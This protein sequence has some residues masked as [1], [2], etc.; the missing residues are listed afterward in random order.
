MAKVIDPFMK[1]EVDRRDRT[2]NLLMALMDHE[3]KAR[4]QTMQVLEDQRKVFAQ[5]I[6][7][8]ITTFKDQQHSLASM[9]SNKHNNN[10]ND[11][12]EKMMTLFEGLKKQLEGQCQQLMLSVQQQQQQQMLFQQQQQQQHLMTQP[13]QPIIAGGEAS[14][15]LLAKEAAIEKELTQLMRQQAALELQEREVKRREIAVTEREQELAA[16]QLAFSA[17]S[18]GQSQAK[19]LSQG[20]LALSQA[21][22][23]QKVIQTR[24]QAAVR[25]L[26]STLRQAM[27]KRCGRSFRI[28]SQQVLQRRVSD[29][30][31]KHVRDLARQADE[32]SSREIVLQ[33]RVSEEQR[34]YQV[35]ESQ[36]LQL[37]RDLNTA[38][39]QVELLVKSQSIRN[40]QD[41]ELSNQLRQEKERLVVMTAKYNSLA[42]RA[43]KEKADL[44]TQLD[45]ANEKLSKQGSVG[46]TTSFTKQPSSSRMDSS[47]MTSL[48]YPS[49]SLLK[50]LKQGVD[51]SIQA[52]PMEE[53]HYTNQKL[54]EGDD[55][56]EQALL[57]K[58]LMR[59]G[60]KRTAMN[61]QQTAMATLAEELTSKLGVM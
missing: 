56:D 25:M 28:W 59:I 52:S 34:R 22:S 42:Q 17:K 12:N 47:M 2:E 7:N 16:E 26:Y 8:L 36:F 41:S 3:Q 48:D 21:M 13:Q 32:P 6:N 37:N 30:L 4:L 60:A 33:Q 45:A 1:E 24:K 53:E 38:K 5:E 19:D 9:D 57:S 50:Y 43:D 29:D 44:L 35:L 46:L 55:L 31:A 61:A 20:S 10:S 11:N 40:K 39:D 18:R 27:R 51:T 15:S 54:F 58:A 23:Q 49:S 14:S